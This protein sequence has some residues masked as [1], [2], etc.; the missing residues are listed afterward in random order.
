MTHKGPRAASS[1]NRK[2]NFLPVGAFLGIGSNRST[3]TISIDE[4]TTEA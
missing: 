4:S 3:M 2:L 1:A